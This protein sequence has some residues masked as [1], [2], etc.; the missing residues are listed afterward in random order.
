ME[1]HVNDVVRVRIDC[2]C[3]FG[4]F[5]RLIDHNEHKGFILKAN[6]N[7]RAVEID[8]LHDARILRIDNIRNYMDLTLVK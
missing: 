2:P 1:L 6:L 8:Q 5:V 3:E 4:V 7:R